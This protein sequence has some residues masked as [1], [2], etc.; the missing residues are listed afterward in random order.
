MN[1]RTVFTETNLHPEI[2]AHQKTV[3]FQR[4]E[5]T[6]PM[7]FDGWFSKGGVHKTDGF[8]WVI[9]KGGS[10]QNQW[11]FDGWFSK[12]GSTQN[13]WAFDGF[14]N[15]FLWLLK[16]KRPG[17]LFRQ[18]RYF[19]LFQDAS[20]WLQYPGT[21]NCYYSLEIEFET[22]IIFH[23]RCLEKNLISNIFLLFFQ[24]WCLLGKWETLVKKEYGKIRNST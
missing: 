23:F 4:G 22:E 12:G 19:H 3:I 16:I 13:R 9:F 2:S 18:I 21:V 7:A 1:A 6:K 14:W 17:R 11:A 24:Y 10:T 15:V 8:W 20:L 5:Y